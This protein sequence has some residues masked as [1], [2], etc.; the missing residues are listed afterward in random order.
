MLRLASSVVVFV[1]VCQFCRLSAASLTVPQNK[2][3][4]EILDACLASTIPP[5]PPAGRL[6][7]RSISAPSSFSVNCALPAQRRWCAVGLRSFSTTRSALAVEPVDEVFGETL[8]DGITIG[9]YVR[10]YAR[11]FKATKAIMANNVNPPHHVQ[12]TEWPNMIADA[13][14]CGKFSSRLPFLLTMSA[15]MPSCGRQWAYF[16]CTGHGPGRLAA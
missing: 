6:S 11:Q 16:G 14:P 13:Q 1:L 7:H 5:G 15:S 12:W 8:F 10:Q 9:G 4:A 2:L 3:K